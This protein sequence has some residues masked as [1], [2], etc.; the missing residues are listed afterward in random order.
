MVRLCQKVIGDTAG[1]N[2]DPTYN[3]KLLAPHLIDNKFAIK[4]MRKGHIDSNKIYKTLLENEL[5]I[6][7]ELNHPKC[8]KIFD[9]YEDDKYY[10]VVGEFIRGGS[11]MHRLK[12]YGMP[13]NEWTTFL[14]I[15]QILEALIHI[16]SK[17]IAH[18]DLKLENL[19]FVSENKKDF[20]LKLIDF[21]FAQ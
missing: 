17:N 15:K 18:R 2:N 9:L 1:L 21:G 19:M 10:F 7:R 12:E 3:C 5:G 8:M 6:L 11:V 4:I 20:Q 14:I 13:Y 16:H